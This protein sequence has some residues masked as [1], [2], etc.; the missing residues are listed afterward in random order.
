MNPQS[1]FRK[2]IECAAKKGGIEILFALLDGPKKWLDLEK[3][4][5]EK[6]STSYRIREFIDLGIIHIKIIHDTPTGSKYY[7]LTPFGRKIVK[8]LKS[9]N[10]EC[11]KYVAASP[12]KGR[13]FID[14]ENSNE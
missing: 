6:K 7:E 10:E 1:D 11:E 4:V 12:P 8:L 14:M 5:K 13:A 9:I 2:I 3:V